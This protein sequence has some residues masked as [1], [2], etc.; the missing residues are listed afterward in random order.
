M[1]VKL[2]AIGAAGFSAA[3]LG[4]MGWLIYAADPDALGVEIAVRAAGPEA[5]SETVAASLTVL[6]AE[7]LDSDQ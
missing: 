2:Y 4:A 5:D 6:I 1:S 3:M 7:L